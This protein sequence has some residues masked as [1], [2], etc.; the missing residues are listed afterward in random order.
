MHSTVF[1]RL[2]AQHMEGFLFIMYYSNSV[3]PQA[4]ILQ[5]FMFIMYYWNTVSPLCIMYYSN[6]TRIDL[7][8]IILQFS[9]PDCL[10]LYIPE[11]SAY[12]TFV[13]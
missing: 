13:L 3:S 7:I 4:I 5:F 6:I 2:N 11:P 1:N 9:F 12:K 8:A 10:C